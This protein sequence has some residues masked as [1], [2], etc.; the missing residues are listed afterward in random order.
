MN[1]FD[2]KA[3]KVWFSTTDINVQLDNGETGSVPI[4][5]FSILSK[6]TPQQLEKV[7]IVNGYA[8]HWEELDE[9]ISIAGFF[10]KNKER[11]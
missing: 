7:A 1:F 2:Y 4:S 6:A 5:N 11:V 9:D 8:L 3:V 10:E